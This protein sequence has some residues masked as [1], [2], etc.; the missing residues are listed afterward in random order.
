MHF[1]HTRACT[2]IGNFDMSDT[3]L[4]VAHLLGGTSGL[5][6]SSP[7]TDGEIEQ[8][9]AT[10]VRVAKEIERQTADPPGTMKL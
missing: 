8:M 5:N 10:A 7:M 6:L 4:I 2:K 9:V 1:V 3:P